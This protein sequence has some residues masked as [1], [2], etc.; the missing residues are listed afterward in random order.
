[1]LTSTDNMKR[2]NLSAFTRG[3]FIG[4]FIPSLHTSSEFEIAVKHYQAGESEPSHIHRVAKE[5][6]VIISGEVEMNGIKYTKNDII[7]IDPGEYSNFHALTDAATVVF[8]MPSVKD[9]KYLA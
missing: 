9:D 1:M 7:E 5:W 4:N 2:Y 3:W 6:T 8:K